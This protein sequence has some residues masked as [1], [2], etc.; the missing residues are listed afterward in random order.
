MSN[1]LDQLKNLSTVVADSGDLN[2]IKAY[3]PLDAT[4]NPSLIL[5]AIQQP[6][7]RPL[8]EEAVQRTA[9]I[10]S[11][12][13][14]A[15]VEACIDQVVV[16]FGAAILDIV[17]GRVSTEVDARLSFDTAASI[18]KGRELIMLYENRGIPR[19]RILIKLAST[20]E[21]VMAA[22]TLQ[23][24]N[25][26]CNMTLLFSMA[27]AIACAQV[28]VTL[29][30]PFVGR[31]LDWY[32]A[33]TSHAFTAADDPGVLSVK[34]IYHYYKK[35]DYKTEIMG[36]S[37][38]NLDQ[39]VELAGCDLLTISPSL[40]EELQKSDRKVSRKLSM[41]TAQTLDFR[42]LEMDEARFRWMLN[43]DPMASDKLSDGIRIF[44]KDMQKVRALI[45]E[46]LYR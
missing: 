17:P 12:S 30:S 29:I 1:A 13:G 43:E 38:R 42:R 11:L 6:E 15:L 23:K 10:G 24:E 44:A 41:E 25:I 16:A 26:H 46:V 9:R 7:Y 22:E 20:W 4:T 33:N 14:E 39:I 35:H 27:Q 2:S 32:Q 19:E 3:A 21:G 45:R 34:S 8:F 31:I 5:K 36:A 40:L 18:A 28:G 37:F